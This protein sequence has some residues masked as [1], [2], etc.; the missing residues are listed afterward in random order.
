M[1]ASPD[2]FIGRLRQTTAGAAATGCACY[3]HD[4]PLARVW[5]AHVELAVGTTVESSTIYHRHG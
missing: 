1:L 4:T 5:S 2:Y 3:M